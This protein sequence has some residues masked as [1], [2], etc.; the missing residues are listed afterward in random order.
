[1]NLLLAEPVV[2]ETPDQ[3]QEAYWPTS[4]VVLELVQRTAGNTSRQVSYQ[5]P[6]VTSG[7]PDFHTN[8]DP[9]KYVGGL[10]YPRLLGE[11]IYDEISARRLGMDERG[12]VIFERVM[13]SLIGKN[14]WGGLSKTPIF[15]T[16]PKK[17][18][19]QV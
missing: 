19:R 13:I 6:S 8:Y 5:D 1:M 10:L 17:I 12:E 18:G 11:R 7:V 14:V 2:T 9:D 3:E 4:E 15:S 16:F